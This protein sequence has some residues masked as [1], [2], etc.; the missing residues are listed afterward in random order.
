MFATD[1]VH[2]PRQSLSTV[3]LLQAVASHTGNADKGQEQALRG[4]VGLSNDDSDGDNSSAAPGLTARH[5]RT[6]KV[7]TSTLSIQT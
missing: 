3:P 7:R 4:G 1:R 6:V 2:R 5:R